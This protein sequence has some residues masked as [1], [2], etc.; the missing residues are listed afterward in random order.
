MRIDGNLANG[1]LINP[2]ITT[3]GVGESGSI[4]AGNVG[5]LKIGGSLLG[6]RVVAT[7][8]ISALTVEGD[9]KSSGSNEAY[10]I[11]GG[12]GVDVALPSILVK[13]QATNAHFLAGY[14]R[15]IQSDTDSSNPT[16]PTTTTRTF[17]TPANADA[18]IGTIQFNGAVQNIDIVAGAAPGAFTHNNGALNTAFR[19]YGDG[20]FGTADDV[21]ATDVNTGLG[22]ID[23]PGVSSRIAQ[24]IF[25]GG[26]TANAIE[27][28]IVAQQI[29]SVYIDGD[30]QP[31]VVSLSPVEVQ[32]GSKFYYHKVL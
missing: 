8:A 27:H 31:L 1:T 25:N 18:Q 24:I 9:V 30:L 23:Q 12:V 14:F 4:V 6:G 32:A 5:T 22:A 7:G 10:V 17:Y 21:I 29:G 28:G 26:I 16:A 2:T 13:G 19:S 20:K 3:G 15:D 11:A